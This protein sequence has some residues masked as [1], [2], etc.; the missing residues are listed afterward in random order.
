MFK[1][2][3]SEVGQTNIAITYDL[4]FARANDRTIELADGK[5]IRM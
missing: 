5:A 3:S 4:Y 1:E 2:I